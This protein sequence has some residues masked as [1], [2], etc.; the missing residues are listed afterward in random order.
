MI[1]ATLAY[2]YTTL[3]ALTD[4]MRQKESQRNLNKKTGLKELDDVEMESVDGKSAS[5]SSSSLASQPYFFLFVGGGEKNK[6]WS[7]SHTKLAL[8]R[9]QFLLP[10]QDVGYL[11]NSSGRFTPVIARK[12]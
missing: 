12:V 5:H 1:L 11:T 4:R 2:F 6:V 7:N 10:K 8:H 9:Q 3:F